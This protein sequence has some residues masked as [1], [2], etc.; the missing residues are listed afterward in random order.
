MACCARRSRTC[1]RIRIRQ[2]ASTITQQLARN[3]FPLKGRTFGRKILEIYV[4]RRI[5][6]TLT[7]DQI[8]EY[9]LNRIYLGSGLYGVEAASK[10]Y[11]GKPARDLTLGESATLAGSDQ[12]PQ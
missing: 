6:T 5:E 11:F 12:K 10:G 1:A 9:Y 7:K 2:G 8:M 4:A 3:T